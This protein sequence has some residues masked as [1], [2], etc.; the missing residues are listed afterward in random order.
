MKMKTAALAGC[1]AIAATIGGH[2]VHAESMPEKVTVLG[3]NT[4]GAWYPISM[5]IGQLLADAGTKGTGGLGGGNS[6]IISVSTGQAEMGLTFTVTAAMAA[7]GEEPFK[8]KVNNVRGLAFLFDNFF[9]ILVTQESGV[10]TVADL[11]GK[12]FASQPVSAGST[13][14]FRMILGAHGLN[15]EDD[16]DIVVRGG[17][18]QGSEAVQDRRAV[19]FM[20]GSIVPLG[21]IAETCVSVPCRLLGIDDANLKSLKEINDGFQRSVLPAGTYQGVPDAVDG[22]GVGTILVVNEAMPEGEAFW[23]VKQFAE[24]IDALRAVHQGLG[25]ITV[26]DMA[27]VA[28]V[29][30]HPGAEKYFKQ[31]GV[32]N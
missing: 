10:R 8:N 20:S 23:I 12:A 11:K 3:G 19:G 5:G 18:K 14:F 24:R 30:M 17:T 21:I 22:I 32:M 28:G 15:G 7:N 26:E 1:I 31:V 2:P 27:K 29:P 13:T 9:H 16:L 25:G 4:G 6:N